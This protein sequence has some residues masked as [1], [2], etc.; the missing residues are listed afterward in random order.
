M[1]ET[2]LMYAALNSA[3]V[4]TPLKLPVERNLLFGDELWVTGDS[5]VNLLSC[6]RTC[7]SV[8]FA[9]IGVEV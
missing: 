9:Q 5:L 3:L 6:Q 4:I 2:T 1:W 8:L 7:G